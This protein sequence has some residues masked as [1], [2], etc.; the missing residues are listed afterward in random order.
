MTK[1][2]YLKILPGLA[3]AG[4]LIACEKG[5]DFDYVHLPGTGP[6]S[7]ANMPFTSA[8]KVNSGTIVF[9]SGITAAPGRT[10]GSASGQSVVLVEGAIPLK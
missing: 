7:G 5:S 10:G 6:A 9:L 4:L 3:A 8:I 1:P 2:C